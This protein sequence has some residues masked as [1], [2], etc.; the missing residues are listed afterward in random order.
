MK[1]FQTLDKP[2]QRDLLILFT[3]GLLFWSCMASLLPTL[4][5]YAGHIGASKQNIGLIMG[6]FAIGLL[7]F[8]PRL[9]QMVDQSGRKPVL[10]LGI[11]V[12]AIA[13]VGYWLAKTVPLLILLRAFHGISIAAFTT[14][15]ST[16]IAD[17]APENKRGEVIGYMSLVNPIGMAI[18]P[19]AGG[20]IQKNI[21]YKELFGF[22]T[23][24]AV[25]SFVCAYF[26]KCPPVITKPKTEVNQ[27]ESTQ[28]EPTKFNALGILFS[29][30]VRI[31]TFV[32]FMVGI[33]FGTLSTF[34]PLFIESLKI[35]FNPGFFYT[36]AAITSFSARL[37]TGKI[38]DR[39]GRGLFVTVGIICYCLSMFMLWQ[40]SSQLDFILAAL[41]E[42][43][44]GGIMLPMII[45]IMTDRSQPQERGRIFA[46]CVGGFDVG[47]AIAGPTLGLIAE[48]SGYPDMFLIAAIL[49]LITIFV[50]LTQSS[51][52]L[53]QSFQF[54][55]GRGKDAYAMK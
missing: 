17:L 16:L 4:P 35:D 31:P 47:I 50:F 12:A 18:G 5:Q 36:C 19:A 22:A 38:S 46:L 52:T 53:R 42:G 8:R 9:G 29:P 30:R 37:V 6:S 34:V 3:A 10:L 15:Y 2:L 27:I 49:C 41:V 11:V 54:A 45:T 32:M 7:L 43:A 39:I 51:K 24:L 1:A 25:L 21:G 33:A 44:G 23:F 20:L 48:R 26:I 14:A 13:P 40:A 28:I 55:V